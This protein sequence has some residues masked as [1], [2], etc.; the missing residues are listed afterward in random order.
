MVSLS[1]FSTRMGTKFGLAR[2]I[3]SGYLAIVAALASCRTIAPPLIQM[4]AIWY[5]A[6]A[7]VGGGLD[8]ARRHGP[9]PAEVDVVLGSSMAQPS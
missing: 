4:K 6:R 9:S 1:V 8:V 7:R 5:G 3:C 2:N